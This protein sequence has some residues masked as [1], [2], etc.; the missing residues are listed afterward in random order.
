MPTPIETV[1]AFFNAYPEGKGKIAIQRW[2]TT[3]TVWVNEGVATTTGIDEAFALID[4]LEDA[5]GIT[6]VRI[7]MLSIA[8]DGNKV[9]TERFDRF[10]RADGSEIGAAKVMGIL[11]LDGDK[12]IAWRDYFDTS[13]MQKTAE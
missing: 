1:N 9:L 8:A 6:T 2:F 7:E 3:H 5:F 11:E 10:E 13:F 12:I 4:K